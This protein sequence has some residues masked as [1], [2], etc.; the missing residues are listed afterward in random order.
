[1]HLLSYLSRQAFACIS[2]WLLNS[3]A[4]VVVMKVVSRMKELFSSDISQ[5]EFILF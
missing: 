1:M 4:V 2:L 5:D 3:S